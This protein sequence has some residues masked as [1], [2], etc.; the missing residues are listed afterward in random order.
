[1]E[2]L[3][4]ELDAQQHSARKERP[5]SPRQGK[6][7]RLMAERWFSRPDSAEER[8]R[9]EMICKERLTQRGHSLQT[10]AMKFDC[11]ELVMVTAENSLY[12][13][14]GQTEP[15]DA[16]ATMKV[17][18]LSLQSGTVSEGLVTHGKAPLVRRGHYCFFF[19]DPQAGPVIYVCGGVSWDGRVLFNDM[20]CLELA[21]K[22][23][24]QVVS[25]LPVGGVMT[26]SHN[27]P[28]MYLYGTSW[29]GGGASMCVLH[30]I[31]HAR[32]MPPSSTNGSADPVSAS[33]YERPREPSSQ[34]AYHT[35]TVSDWSRDGLR[36]DDMVNDDDADTGDE[37]DMPLMLPAPGGPAEGDQ[38][39]S[40][41]TAG[42]TP[43]GDGDGEEGP[44]E[45]GEQHDGSRASSRGGTFLTEAEEAGDGAEGE[46]EGGSDAPAEEAGTEAGAPEGGPDD[47]GGGDPL[48][49][50]APP[51]AQDTGAPPSKAVAVSYSRVSPRPSSGPLVPSS[52][53]GSTASGHRL[54]SAP[55]RRP[56]R[57]PA[58]RALPMSPIPGGAWMPHE[59]YRCWYQGSKALATLP[60]SKPPLR[61]TP[62][63]PDKRDF[64]GARFYGR[65]NTHERLYWSATPEASKLPAPPAEPDDWQASSIV[66][67]VA[68]VPTMPMTGTKGHEASDLVDMKSLENW[69]AWIQT[70]P[71]T[72][73]ASMAASLNLHGE[74]KQIFSFADRA[75]PKT[76]T[77][78][79]LMQRR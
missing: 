45:S 52:R 72:L 75:R 36:P 10:L 30:S 60:G 56:P 39:G 74:E 54:A 53:A 38:R 9:A 21:T 31:A 7:S 34:R 49:L 16:G 79:L 55:Q 12:F 51:E 13:L 17:H 43:P 71:G 78:R 22:T 59:D 29:E 15:L 48:L 3:R 64:A 67:H 19:R 2:A 28:S 11:S 62:A 57:V 44:D 24:R 32:L 26:G 33:G 46:P 68:T 27:G 37:G 41:S 61:H 76:A 65:T 25:A 5:P 69:D 63:R 4:E 35:S 77:S 6:S 66:R 58:A 73:D 42:S 47:G 1:V 23:W 50:E 20:H 14:G 18:K 8:Q 70:H 40:E